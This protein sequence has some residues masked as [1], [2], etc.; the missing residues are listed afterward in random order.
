MRSA[1]TAAT[2]RPPRARRA[3]PARARTT[4]AAGSTS[5]RAR[6]R[7]ARVVPRP[8]A[9]RSGGERVHDGNTS[10]PASDG[11]RCAQP[12]LREPVDAAE[13]RALVRAVR[14]GV[15]PGGAEE[16]GRSDGDDDVGGDEPD[17]PARADV[18][19]GASR[20]RAAEDRRERLERGRDRP[21]AP[22]AARRRQSRRRA[23]AARSS[24]RRCDRRRRSASARSGLQPRNATA[25]ALRVRQRDERDRG[26]QREKLRAAR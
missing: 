12:E 19:G 24:A 8:R 2:A 15:H 3:R 26:E 1:T 14:R 4:A 17:P 13:R 25:A 16:C 18:A 9:R 7:R 10:A 6:S 22:P 5:G 20:A 23:R 21:G 11:V